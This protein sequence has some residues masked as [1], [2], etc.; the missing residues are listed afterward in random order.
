MELALFAVDDGKGLVTLPG[1]FSDAISSVIL[2]DSAKRS[3][4]FQ[5][6]LRCYIQNHKR[7]GDPRVRESSPNWRS[8]A[9]EAAQR[10]LSWLARDSIIFFFNTI[11]PS[12]S[13][14]GRRKDFWLRYHDRI[15]DFQVAVSEGDVWKVKSSQQSKDLL[16]YS[17]VDHPTTSAFLMK[18]EG[19]GGHFLVVEFSE[20]GNAAYILRFKAFEA[21][22]VT[23]RTP[24]V[25]LKNHLKFD[26]TC[27]IIHN[28]DW[29]SA[30]SYTLA[31]RFGIRP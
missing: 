11:L 31:S 3:E 23:M 7:L 6:A 28:G 18:F 9:P 29:E 15:K 1:A 21:Q 27:R 22:G 26:K 16:Y 17:R 20:K 25:D 2:S 30:A 19:Y 4:D 14:N 12:N 5:R 10:Y 24:R 8:I 13:E